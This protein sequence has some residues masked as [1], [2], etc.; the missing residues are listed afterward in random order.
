MIEV[1]RR[2][3]NNIFIEAHIADIHFGSFEPSK[4]FIIL[5]EQFLDYIE[6]LP[7][8][9][10][11]SINGDI[12][13]H[14]FMANS[15]AIM[16]ACNFVEA[17]IR[18][19][20]EKNTTLIIVAGTALHDADQL[21]LFYHYLGRCDIRIVERVQFEYVKGKS[22]LVIP[23]LYNMGEAYYNQFL[24]REW[25]DACYMHGTYKGT[26]FG[27]D[28][29]DLSSPREPVFDM[30]AF[31]FCK[32]PIISGHVH[33]PGCFDKHFYY[34]G[35][36]YR[37]RFGEEEDKGFLILLHNIDSMQ[38]YTHFEPITSF[39][40]DTVNLDSMLSA[41]PHEVIE[42]IKHKKAEGIENIRVQFTQN[43][44]DK[45]AIIKAYFRNYPG[46]KIDANFKNEA[47][48]E[49]TTKLN[50]QYQQYSFIFDKSATPFEIL[51]KYI[52]MQEGSTFITSDDLIS[53]FEEE[54]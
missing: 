41:D 49:E 37:W 1:V 8:L 50:D 20:Q 14:K 4:Q 16:Y 45:L 11:V 27:K 24:N 51:A 44:E 6:K 25:Y 3:M 43:A 53:I 23:E 35:S 5:K 19:C 42:Y 32:G 33:T 21:K 9:D 15:D 18:I 17:L 47:V 7:F 26:I 12:F 28:T 29:A 39:R 2:D 46:V 13:D 22:I 52:N 30:N 34:C 40:Y 36:P 38:Y 48:V 31:K 54:L 10:I